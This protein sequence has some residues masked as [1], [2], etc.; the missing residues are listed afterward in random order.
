MYINPKWTAQQIVDFLNERYDKE[1][2][3]EWEGA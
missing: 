1:H 2:P 3:Q